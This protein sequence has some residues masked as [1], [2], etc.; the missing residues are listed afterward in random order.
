MHQEAEA[1]LRRWLETRSRLDVDR[2]RRIADR[3]VFCT[4]GGKNGAGKQIQS[5]YVRHLLRRLARE[6][7][8][9]TGMELRRCHPHGF[10]ATLA[11]ELASEGKSMTAIRDVLGHSSIAVSDRYLRRTRPADA[12]DAVC[13]RDAINAGGRVLELRKQLDALSADELR[14]LLTGAL[15]R[16]A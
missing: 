14:D 1:A 15:G 2:G 12:I 5:S 16:A 4:I 8:A 3:R 7:A 11:V 9:E 13:D 6:I 10:R